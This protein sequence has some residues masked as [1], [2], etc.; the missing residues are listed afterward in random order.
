MKYIGNIQSQANAEVFAVASGALPGGKPV[1]VNSNGTVSVVAEASISEA[2]G[3]AQQFLGDTVNQTQV[4]FDSNSNRIVIA[5]RDANTK[6]AYIVGTVNSANKTISF[7]TAAIFNNVSNTTVSGICFDSTNNKIIITWLNGN[8][9]NRA[10]VIVGDVDPSDN[11]MSFGSSVAFESGQTNDSNPVF[12]TNAGKVVIV[13]VDQADS[14]KGKAI[15]GT[16]SGTSISFGSAAT[17]HTDVQGL[18]VAVYDPTSQKVIIPYKDGSDGD[19]GRCKV[20]TVSG[21]SISFGNMA[22][23]ETSNLENDIA[24]S[25][26][27]NSSKVVVAYTDAGNSSHGKAVVGTVSGTT[28]SFGSSVTFESAASRDIDISYDIAN[29]VNVISYDDAGN[30][31]YGTYI[32]GTVSGTSI[33]FG[34]PEVFISNTYAEASSCYDSTAEKVILTSH[35]SSQGGIAFVLQNAGTSTNLTSENFIGFADGE[36]TFSGGVQVLG[37]AVE[38]EDA[39]I[40]YASITYDTNSDR[41][42]ITYRDDGNSSYGT[43][44]VAEISGSTISFGTPEVFNSGGSNYISSTFDSNSNRVVVAYTDTGNSNAGTAVVGSV[45]ASDNSI[46]F[47]SEAVFNNAD[48]LMQESVSTAFDSDKNRVVIV[49]RDNGNSNVGTAIVGNVN[50]SNNSITFGSEEVFKN[51]AARYMAVTFDETNNKILVAYDENASPLAGFCIVGTVTASDNSITFGSETAFNGTNA[52]N[53]PKA[54]IYDPVSAKNVMIRA[55]GNNS[56]K[57]TAVVVSISGTTPSFGT[58]VVFQEGPIDFQMT[59]ARSADGVV[60]LTSDR[61]TT[62]NYIAKA[63]ELTVSGTSITAATQVAITT[64]AAQSPAGV[65]DPDQDRIAVAYKDGGNGNDGFAKVF[66]PNNFVE[67]RSQIA[68]GKL[69]TIQVGGSINTQQNALTAGQQYFVQEDGTLGLTAD[70]TSVIAGTAVSATDL[71]VKG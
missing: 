48:T 58:A 27:V 64:T 4:A 18:Q 8:E 54:L 60:A 19:R 65:Y 67:T 44:I 5:Y 9:T 12:D 70:S 57:G 26:D 42:V 31:N 68:D 3:S 36:A 52:S 43:A 29:K 23:F 56:E 62:P 40:A 63:T 30:S 33:S 47:G 69:A 1:V 41:A 21:T 32:V 34:S 50:P 66:K 59:L 22:T 16:V 24:V 45:T 35:N 2:I 51:A 55:D 71:I 7:G 17:F 10:Y 25:Y 13:F 28:I 15:V 46:T 11:S 49:Y 6:G 14:R 39:D 20:A 38:F 61:S 37:D 53:A